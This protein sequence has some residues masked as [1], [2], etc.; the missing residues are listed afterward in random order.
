MVEN[1]YGGGVDYFSVDRPG[2]GKVFLLAGP[3]RFTSGTLGIMI[4]A[5]YDGDEL[6]SQPSHTMGWRYRTGK[7][8]LMRNA[9]MVGISFPFESNKRLA[10]ML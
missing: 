8:P 5:E 1:Q 4:A 2:L 3:S 9:R 7:K 6:D 10:S